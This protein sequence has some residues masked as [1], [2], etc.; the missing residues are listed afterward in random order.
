MDVIQRGEWPGDGVLW[1]GGTESGEGLLRTVFFND[2][3][4]F[5]NSGGGTGLAPPNGV[6]FDRDVPFGLTMPPPNLAKASCI[7]D[8]RVFDPK[9]G[10][11]HLELARSIISISSRRFLS[12]YDVVCRVSC[13]DSSPLFLVSISSVLVCPSNE[14]TSTIFSG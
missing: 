3:A 7:D 14:R 13:S 2:N 8:S 6:D 12:L 1:E 9:V 5:N 10:V 4:G 11:P